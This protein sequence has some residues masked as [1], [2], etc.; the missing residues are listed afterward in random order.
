MTLCCSRIPV[1]AYRFMDFD[2]REAYRKRVAEIARYSDCT[3]MEVAQAA[4]DAGAGIEGKTAGGGSATA[5]PA[6][7]CGLLHH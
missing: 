2:S 3:E 6:R 7:A 5:R 1:N 4:L